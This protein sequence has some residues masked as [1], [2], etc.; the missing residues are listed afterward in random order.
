MSE[1]IKIH[2]LP[3]LGRYGKALKDYGNNIEA[4]AKETERQ[5]ITKTEESVSD[6]VLAFFEKMNTLQTQV[7]HQAPEIIKN[8]G[9]NVQFFESTVSGLGFEVKAWTWDEGKND[10]TQKLK[11]DQVDKIKE[12]MKSLQSLL[13]S[14]TEKL[15]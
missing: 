11:V 3:G 5:F 8:Y 2:D 1:I 14:A 10:V 4:A 13:D 6:A 15:I 7:F 9:A 12:V